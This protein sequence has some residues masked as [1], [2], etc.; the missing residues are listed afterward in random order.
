VA[1][2]KPAGRLVGFYDTSG[3]PNESPFI[4]TVGVISREEKWERFD[5]EWSEALADADLPYLHMRRFVREWST[6]SAAADA[7]IDTLARVVKRNVNKVF[8]RGFMWTL[9]RHSIES[10]A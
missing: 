6:R 1:K 8:I 7:L 2:G 5:D 9:S 3:D 10:S 4:V